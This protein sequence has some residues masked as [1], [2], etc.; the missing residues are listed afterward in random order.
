MSDNVQELAK[1]VE[2]IARFSGKN[3]ASKIA[4]LEFKF[5]TLN[6]EQVVEHLKAGR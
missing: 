1:S 4:E 3:L 6:R 2:E 5:V